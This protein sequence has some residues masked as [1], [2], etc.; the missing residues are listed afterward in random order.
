MLPTDE[1]EYQIHEAKENIQMME[2]TLKKV[3][4]VVTPALCVYVVVVL[5]CRRNPTW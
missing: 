5:L 4:V 1:A 2:M 3:I